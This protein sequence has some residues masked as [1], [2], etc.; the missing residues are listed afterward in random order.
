[1]A[2]NQVKVS[3][4][5]SIPNYLFP[6]LQAGNGIAIRNNG[7]SIRIDSLAQDVTGPVQNI[8][9][10]GDRVTVT[11]TSNYVIISADEQT[12]DHKVMASSSDTSPDYLDSKI[13]QGSGITLSTASNYIMISADTQTGD[14]KVMASSSDTS[15]DYLDSKILQGSGI[16]LTKTN[17]DI[18]IAAD[19][20]TGDRKVLVDSSD[21][22]PQYL[23]VKLKSGVGINISYYNH[24]KMEIA[25]LGQVKVALLGT[26]D[27]LGN[28]ILQGSNITLTKTDNDITIAADTQT[29][30][31]KLLVDG[32]DT[33]PGYLSSKLTAGSNITITNN[34]TDLEISATG[35]GGGMTNPMTTAGD[36]IVGGVSGTPDRLGIGANDQIFT[37]YSGAP[38]WRNLVNG[39]GITLETTSN[40]IKITADTQTGDH[41]VV[42]DGN[43]T[44]PDYLASKLT[45]GS[46]ITLTN[47]G[48]DLEISATDVGFANPM[49]AAGDLI[50][51]GSSGVA[52]R[53][54]VG[55]ENQ[56]LTVSS[57]T[58]TW[59]AIPTQTGDHKVLTDSS[60]TVQNYLYDK[61][62]ATNGLSKSVY[63][64]GST[65]LLSLGL[66]VSGASENQ[67]LSISSG[68]PAWVDRPRCIDWF[69]PPGTYNGT[70]QR[71]A[72]RTFYV[73]LFPTFA[74]KE[75]T[76]FMAM[77]TSHNASDEWRCAIYNN[78]R[79]MIYYGVQTGSTATIAQI[80]LTKLQD[81]TFDGYNPVYLAISQHTLGGS[82][83]A[84]CT[85]SNNVD[86]NQFVWYEDVALTSGRAMP[87][88]GMTKGTLKLPL[89][90]IRGY[91]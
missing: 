18:T 28:K 64:V 27:Y 41:K 53:L 20:Q 10:A 52:D 23:G 29:G 33:T 38:K 46:N 30:D 76:Q 78:S 54:G 25:S 71:R 31:H 86:N 37:V 69:C 36:L 4:A 72:D 2:E 55:T 62:V 85:C 84:L 65:R 40:Y 9:K 63:A 22:N 89:I 6:K 81:Y 60:D 56:V 82:T 1:M 16:T 47:N 79:T 61:V 48:T 83:S 44:T 24:D 67:V 88:S 74:F 11:N 15:P 50:V 77:I 58:P 49:T 8:I 90:G 80:N 13:L 42:V 66:Y 91:V 21:T 3:Q 75:V 12:G 68:S 19:T 70:Y 5:D 34:G 14:R 87:S 43:D 57:G 35:G 17:N 39:S 32:N 7:S 51:G 45:A 26:M 59:A 73:R